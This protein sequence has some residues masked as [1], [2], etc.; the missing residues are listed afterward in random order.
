MT[1]LTN[2]AV[3]SACVAVV[4]LL[5]KRFN[6]ITLNDIPGPKSE[7]FWLGHVGRLQRELVGELDFE[8][9]E[10]FGGVAHIKGPLGQDILWVSD[11]R[12]MQFIHNGGYNFP[13]P[14]ERMA[15][16]IMTTDR[17][18]V[19][20][21]DDTHRRQ[22]KAMSPAFGAPESRALF[23]IF[24]RC[25]ESIMTRWKDQLFDTP[26]Q[27]SEFNV[28]TWLS[29]ATLDAIGE[30]AF[31]HKFGTIDNQQSEFINAYRGLL[32]KAHGHPKDRKIIFHSLSRF[33]PLEFLIFIYNRLPYYRFVHWNREVA[34]KFARQMLADKDA[35]LA[36]GADNHDV[37]TILVRANNSENEQRKLTDYEMV[38]QMRTI[39]LAGHETTSLSL[40]WGLLEL[41]KRPDIQNK[42]RKEIHDMEAA[43]KGRGFIA[44]DMDRMPYTQ[45][46]VKEILR[47]NPAAY[48]NYRAAGH[49]MAIPLARPITTKSGKEIREV[50][51]A[52]GTRIILSIVGYNRDKAVWG[53]DAHE[54]NPDRW[55]NK[56]EKKET[57]T[58][59]GGPRACIGWRFAVHEIQAFLIELVANFEFSPTEACKK[60]RREPCNLMSPTIEGEWDKGVQLPLKVTLVKR[61]T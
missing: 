6:R 41:A 20:A 9:Q 15:F 51:V 11:P 58:F 54:F 12:A 17:G 23:P 13:K 16:S 36:K 52:K 37:M 3:L 26:D 25:A 50:P 57:A 47:L 14:T 38:S 40:S 31:D 22:R 55:L 2:F 49:D 33:F 56:S 39:L 44:A 4:Y 7:S 61:E 42:L 48:Y 45:A 1:S 8:W 24:S 10:Q 35:A 43:V 5:Y 28:T 59:A 34:H 18:L 60:V 46:C 29:C 32:I 30:A 21:Q 27:S 19:T 53:Q